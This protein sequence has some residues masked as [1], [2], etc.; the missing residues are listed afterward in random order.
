MDIKI[1][2]ELVP[3]DCS[4]ELEIGLHTPPKGKN[5]LNILELMESANF[6]GMCVSLVAVVVEV[7]IY[8][9]KNFFI[10]LKVFIVK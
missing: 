7:C 6:D 3:V 1:Q 2:S 10:M 5:I 8:C 9:L 4:Q